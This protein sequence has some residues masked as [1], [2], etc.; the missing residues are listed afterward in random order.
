MLLFVL[1]VFLES[2]SRGAS[3]F[4]KSILDIDLNLVD[5]S[6]SLP[7]TLFPATNLNNI[8][9]LVLDKGRKPQK[10][11]DF[12]KKVKFVNATNLNVEEIANLY[13]AGNFSDLR[14]YVRAALSVNA[15]SSEEEDYRDLLCRN[16]SLYASSYCMSAEEQ[17]ANALFEGMETNSLALYANI[18]SSVIPLKKEDGSLQEAEGYGM[19]NVLAVQDFSEIG[20][21]MPTNGEKRWFKKK[22]NW[23]EM[24][25]QPNDILLVFHGKVGNMTIVSPDFTDRSWVLNPYSCIIRA[26]KEGVHQCDP[27]VLY[28]Y[29]HSEI[30]RNYLQSI[31]NSDGNL[32]RLLLSSLKEMPVPAEHTY[33]VPEI[34]ESF[35]ELMQTA[36]QI[37]ELNGRYRSITQRYWRP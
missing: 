17:Q 11:E 24:F 20:Y 6:L 37:E 33:S 14:A 7:K 23:D 27:R 32:P 26:K 25:L 12:R 21:T 19:Y 16:S 15:S 2:P 30:A 13:A 29:F 5:M 18:I 36:R 9:V 28:M 4:R 10:S 22:K 31:T 8:P 3:A 1:P 34:V 35:E